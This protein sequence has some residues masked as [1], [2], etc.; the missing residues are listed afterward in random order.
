MELSDAD[1]LIAPCGI[2]CGICRGHL[3]VKNKCQGCRASDTSKPKTRVT[4]QIKTCQ[5]FSSGKANY[6]F[7]CESFPC[8]SLKQ[9][10]KRYRTKYGMSVIENLLTI[11]TS[12]L[13]KF[14][15]E[16][17]TRW[18]CKECGGTVCVHTGTC[19]SC[20]LKIIP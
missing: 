17:K 11:K 10:D 14:L 1:L 20:Q 3:R 8:G 12:G 7:E 9:L 5:V 16:E 18:T 19:S 6:C 4:C 15:Q 13:N 2:N